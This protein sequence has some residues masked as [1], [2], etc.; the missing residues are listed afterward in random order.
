MCSAHLSQE[1]EDSAMRENPLRSTS[2]LIS[3]DN[4]NAD[5]TGYLTADLDDA[6]A[7]HAR[8]GGYL[9]RMGDIYLVCS[10]EEALGWGWT[11]EELVRLPRGEERRK[12][13]LANSHYARRAMEL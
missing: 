8:L 3:L 9:L 2:T 4:F 12:G 7:S 10:H 11:P 6:R 1:R 13:D 5:F